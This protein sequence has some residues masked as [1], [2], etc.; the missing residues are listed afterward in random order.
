[1]YKGESSPSAN[2]V[3]FD[4]TMDGYGNG[5]GIWVD[6]ILTTGNAGGM[7]NSITVAD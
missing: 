4:A 7:A 1:M 5:I 2:D 3:V 6:I